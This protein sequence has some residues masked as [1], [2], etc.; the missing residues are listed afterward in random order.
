V[1]TLRSS[2]RCREAI[3]FPGGA[4][5]EYLLLASEA[6][7]VSAAFSEGVVTITV[8][9]CKLTDWHSSDQIGISAA[10]DSQSG[11][12]LEVL[13]EK[14]FRCLDP[15]VRDDQSDAFENP[16]VAHPVC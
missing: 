4:R 15:L 6:N 9:T 10:I 11:K 2:G 3:W 7:E 12:K 16:L 1:G 5:L 13:I 8:P 14:D